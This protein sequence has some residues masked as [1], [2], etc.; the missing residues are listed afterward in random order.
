[1]LSNLKS[2]MYAEQMIPSSFIFAFI[3]TVLL[4]CANCEQPL[5]LFSKTPKSA[6]TPGRQKNTPEM[7]GMENTCC[8][9]LSVGDVVHRE[10]KGNICGRTSNMGKTGEEMQFSQVPFRH[11]NHIIR[12]HILKDKQAK[13]GRER[14]KAF[15]EKWVFAFIRMDFGPYL[16][17]NWTK[18][19]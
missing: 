11:P 13:T 1:M 8:L 5:F 6:Y 2:V 17:K 4:N 7:K 10:N 14:W 18:W 19:F 16:I 3:W 9:G 15:K 12:S